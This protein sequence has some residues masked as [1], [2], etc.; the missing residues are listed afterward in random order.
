MVLPESPLLRS[1]REARSYSLSFREATFVTRGPGALLVAALLLPQESRADSRL[2]RGGFFERSLQRQQRRRYSRPVDH[3]LPVA[4]SAGGQGA[5]TRVSSRWTGPGVSGVVAT[6]RCASG[7][8]GAVGHSAYLVSFSAPGP[9]SV[10]TRF[11]SL[12]VNPA[13]GR[14][15]DP[16]QARPGLTGLTGS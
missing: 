5:S 8:L 15:L 3:R 1:G 7:R 9:S 4:R 11:P 12:A 10:P 6:G 2:F 14:P 13:R 16:H